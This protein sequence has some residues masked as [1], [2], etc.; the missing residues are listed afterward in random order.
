MFLIK[1]YVTQNGIF[2]KKFV[3][4]SDSKIEL[5][6]VVQIINAKVLY[7]GTEYVFLYDMEMNPIPEI[8]DYINFELQDASPNYRY[9][10]LNAL[11]FLYYFLYLYNL[12]LR[13]LTKNDINNFL[14]FLQGVSRDGTL[15]RLNLVTSRAHSTIQT[16]IPIY[17]NFVTYLGYKESPFLKR[18]SKYKLIYSA[19]SDSPLKINQYETSISNYKPEISTPRYINVLEFK[20]ILEVIRE[21]FTLREECIV[22][23]MFENGLRIGEVLGLTNED[24]VENEQGNFLYIRNRCTD[25]FDQLA[26]GCMNV[27]NKRTYTSRAYKTK[28]IGYQ[29]VYLNDSLL[30]KIND[31]VNEYHTN[32]S[33]KFRERYEKL[34]YADNIEKGSNQNFYLFINNVGK[35]LSEN[36]WGKI[37]RSIFHK[38]GLNIDKKRRETNLSH[39]FRHGFAMFMVK[40]KHVDERTL[41]LLL[42]HRSIN[43]VKYYYRPTDEEVIQ[44]RTDFVNSMYTIIP[45]LRI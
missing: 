41:Q 15:Y 43:S 11:K 23:L 7:E 12:N 4:S 34:T 16:Y 8:F 27:K 13:S 44:L 1:E 20:Q 31:Y 40:Y 2:Y 45:E 42:R 26:K 6:E 28:D 35:P 38:A 22:R 10:A 19:D 33:L 29:V 37:L 25:S 30:E 32:N 17:R 21:D 39:R 5:S 3:L 36:L 14:S 9:T 18:S 24:I